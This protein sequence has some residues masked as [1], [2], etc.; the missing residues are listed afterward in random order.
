[1]LTG[2]IIKVSNLQLFIFPFDFD[3]NLF[4]ICGNEGGQLIGIKQTFNGD[5]LH[6]DKRGGI[7]LTCKTH[8]R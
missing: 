1:M 3:L 4:R 8:L 2:V 6:F 5:C 7:A